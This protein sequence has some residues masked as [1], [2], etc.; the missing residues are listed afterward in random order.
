[1]NKTCWS[2]KPKHE[3]EFKNNPLSGIC[4]FAWLELLSTRWRAID[5]RTYWQRVVFLTLLSSFN[6]CL[7]T[8][9]WLLY[10]RAV[11]RTPIDPRPVFVLG[12]PRTGTTLLHTLL[13]LDEELFGVCTTFCAGFPSSFLWFERFKG[14]FGALIDDTR[15]MDGMPLSFDLPQEDEI[16]VNV[17]SAGQV[18]PYMPLHFMTE[19]PSYRP[20]FSFE[21]APPAARRRWSDTFLFLLRKLSLRSG[22]RRLLL[23]SPVHTARIKL[24]R[25][26]FPEAKFVYVHRHPLTV[27][28][29][30]SHMADTTYWYSYFAKPT[31]HQIQEFILNQF[32]QLWR[33]YDAARAEVPH[34]HLTEISYHELTS[35]PVKALGRVYTALGIEGFEERQV[36]PKIRHF[37]DSRMPSYQRNTFQPLPPELAALVAAR[38]AEFASALGYDFDDERAPPKGRAR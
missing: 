38:W 9:E 1:M 28:K 6:S 34:G 4:L 18:S 2:Y 32:V 10:G 14:L 19:E 5:W 15:P 21:S 35:D 13:A 25:E 33:D 29:S 16:A 37:L 11:T 27:F 17:L 31:S 7:A 12:H 36:G 22:G 24:L 20:F 23:K 26:L 8:V 3:W 30:A